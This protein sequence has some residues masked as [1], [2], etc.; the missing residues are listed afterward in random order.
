MVVTS[1]RLRLRSPGRLPYI[2]ALAAVLVAAGAGTME[3]VAAL[4]RSAPT[5]GRA[6][7]EVAHVA[8]SGSVAAAPACRGT[9]SEVLEPAATTPPAAQDGAWYRVD[10]RLDEGGSI[11]GQALTF[12]VDGRAAELDLA[13]ESAASGPFGNGLAIVSDDGHESVVAVLDVGAGCLHRL[14]RTREIIRRAIVDPSRTAL[15]EHRLDRTS[16]ASVGVWWRPL[17]GSPSRR[18]LAPIGADPRFGRTFSTEL[19]WSDDGR[20]AVQSCGEAS[21]R[22]EVLDITSGHIDR[23]VDDRRQGD[24]IA[25][26]GRDLVRYQAC[27]G[28]PCPIDIVDLV[29]G[30]RRAIAERAGLARVDRSPDGLRLTHELTGARGIRLRSVLLDRTAERFVDLAPG[31]M[32]APATHRARAGMTTPPGWL[33]VSRDGRPHGP[34]SEL[35]DP[36]NGTSVR[37]TEV[38]R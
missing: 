28:L 17:D 5:V 33:L 7:A 20:L 38:T 36:T 19:L 21:C 34:G 1:W 10:A 2:A 6:D 4:D 11:S 37:L 30:A 15:V 31:T 9:I 23:A 24:I 27:P 25:V 8:S 26:T 29:T 18:L 3:H 22:T 14:D 35:L 12:G 32:L 13:V 16:R